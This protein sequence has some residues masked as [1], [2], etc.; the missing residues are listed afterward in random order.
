MS[1]QTDK[2]RI[3]TL[4]KDLMDLQHSILGN[5]QM[6]IDGFYGWAEKQNTIITTSINN[7]ETKIEKFTLSNSNEWGELKV[8]M[9]MITNDYINLVE[10][11]RGVKESIKENKAS[12][13]QNSN[14][15]DA[16]ER[17]MLRYVALITGISIAIGFFLKYVLKFVKF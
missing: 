10:D 4:E 16:I 5:E 8:T 14:K 13:E 3:K 2:E 7:I 6:R 15:I 17:K 9:Q 1:E 11:V 12:A